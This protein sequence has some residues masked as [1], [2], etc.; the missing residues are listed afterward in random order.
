MAAFAAALAALCLTNAHAKPPAWAGY[1]ANAQH[2]APAP[3]AGKKLT[4]ILWQTPVDLDP[5][6]Q[7]DGLFIHY[8]SPMITAANT[9]VLAVKTTATGGWQL[10]G[11]AGTTGTQLWT[12]PSDFVAPSSEWTPAFPAGMAPNSTVYAAGAG[13]TVLYRTQPDQAA[14]STGRYAFYGLSVYQNNVA[15]LT[16]DVQINTPITVGPDKTM[17]FGFLAAAKNPANLSSGIARLATTGAGTWISAAAASGDKTMTELSFNCAPAISADGSTVY[18]AVSNGS[19]GYLLGL[20]SKTLK[21]LYK[22]ALIDPASGQPALLPDIA[23]SAPT[24]GPDGDVYYGVLENPF[25]NHD[26]RGW[27]LHF[28]K[29]L[30]TL[31]IPGS[32]GWDDTAS[33]VPASA[34]PSYTGTS[35][36]LLMTKYNNYYG[37][38]PL[39]DGHNKIAVLD[40][41]ATQQDEYSKQP[42]TV[43]QE[44]LTI[45]GPT[46]YPGAPQ[47]A[48]Y[49]WCDNDAV[50]DPTTRSVFAGSE[51]GHL[52]RWSLDSNRFT[53][54]AL[55]NQPQD[56]AYTPSLVGPDGTVYAINNAVLYAVK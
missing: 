1:A 22:A 35:A 11:R 14:G 45:L 18:I 40:P 46:Q 19:S 34:V 48:V 49:E 51:D 47:G 44:V 54:K 8:A 28:D 20:D 26:N 6:Y 42:V 13:G 41:N 30:K 27:L 32:F 23:S 7:N 38:G 56:E 36:Y 10:E 12:L 31:K 53:Q 37:I 25:P 5:Q 24:L 9:V 3:K 50:V 55:L 16:K 4:N 21:T 52:Y 29:T 39:G 17:F 15:A 43:M 33:V 2:T